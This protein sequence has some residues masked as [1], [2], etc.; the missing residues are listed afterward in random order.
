MPAGGL[1]LHQR[2]PEWG[3]LVAAV[4]QTAPE[5][6]SFARE[7]AGDILGTSLMSS[8]IPGRGWEQRLRSSSLSIPL[9]LSFPCR[10]MT[11]GMQVG[12]FATRV[13]GS[14]LER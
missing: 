8:L 10:A 14:I 1:L 5:W 4:E 2:K 12:T 11:A 3:H 7:V 13:R 9:T 6:I